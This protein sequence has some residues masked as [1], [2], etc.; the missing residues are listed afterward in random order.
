VGNT[1]LLPA[2]LAQESLAIEIDIPRQDRFSTIITDFTPGIWERA[3]TGIT[4]LDGDPNERFRSNK[5]E[6]HNAR[7]A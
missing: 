4:V 5:A 7:D 2:A 3:G 6:I 1:L